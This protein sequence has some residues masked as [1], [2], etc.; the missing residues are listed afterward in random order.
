[1]KK[2]LVL[3]FFFL[4]TGG[5]TSIPVKSA[6]PEIPIV[7]DVVE[8]PN[9]DIVE[10]E[11]IEDE[12]VPVGSVFAK[13]QFD[14]VVKTSYVQ[15]TILHADD[16]KDF[17]L[18]IGDKD[19][20]RNLP[21]EI[22]TVEPGYFFIALPVGE[23][24]IKEIAIPVGTT[25][26]VEPIDIAFSVTEDKMTY[27]GTLKVLGLKEKIKLGG[28]PV[29]KPGFEYEVEVVDER[30]EA[31]QELRIRRP[32]SVLSVEINVMKILSPE[33]AIPTEEKLPSLSEG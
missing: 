7:K 11:I 33:D 4:F 17:R 13:T 10:D 5:C 24:R 15:L 28:V 2:L 29:I 22:E 30:D 27:L 8:E 32:E 14:G 19:R 23:Y 1:M 20:Q 16:E 21:W 3:F 12:F 26:A 31:L 25:T 6:Q 18:V 9:V